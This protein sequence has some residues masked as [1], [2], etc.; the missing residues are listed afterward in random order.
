MNDDRG[1]EKNKPIT[2]DNITFISQ[3]K[4][5][6]R[7][8]T[9]AVKNNEIERG[10]ELMDCLHLKESFVVAAQIAYAAGESRMAD[11]VHEVKRAKFKFVL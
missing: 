8:F 9:E 7:I 10:L 2:N 4:N 5:T 1:I 11:R 6:L 3:E